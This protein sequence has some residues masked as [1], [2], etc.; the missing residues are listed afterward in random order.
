MLAAAAAKIRKRRSIRTNRDRA[1]LLSAILTLFL[2]VFVAVVFSQAG[3]ESVDPVLVST[4]SLLISVGITVLVTTFSFVFV[5]LSLVSVQFSP[6]VVRHFWHG[7]SFRGIFLWSSIAVFLFCFAVLFLDS[8]T[9]HLLAVLLGTYQIFVLFPVFLGYLA[10]NLNAASITKTIADKTVNEIANCYEL[11]ELADVEQDDP[12]AI[13]SQKSGFLEKVDTGKLSAVF[14]RLKAKHSGLTFRTTNY[15]GSFIE[16]GSL[17][18][19]FD[20][21]IDIND[22]LRTQIA[23]CFIVGKFRSLDQDI[24]YGIRQLVDIGVKAISPAVNDP[25]T[26]VNCIHY[27]GVILKELAI[28]D[29]RSNV[30]KRLESEGIYLKEPSFE[31]YTDDALDQIYKFGR[32]DHVIVRTIVGVLTEIV[33]IVPDTARAETV[34]RE[35]DEMELGYLYDEKISCPFGL[36]EHRNYLRKSLARFY[37]AASER[38]RSL[39][40]ETTAERL[41]AMAEKYLITTE[42]H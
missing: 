11:H 12:F 6:R 36:I 15:L 30:S 10:D 26:C 27:L 34:L 5:A 4:L 8:P 2:V 32:R 13:R 29:D 3:V 17:L 28:R 14:L 21:L 9:L 20:Q 19:K 25:T 37:E 38:M 41:T 33:S 39:D 16:V 40:N 7:D 18:G 42:T 35:I 23:D 22:E 1:M 24:E 31:Q